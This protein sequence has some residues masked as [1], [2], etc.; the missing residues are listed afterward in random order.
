MQIGILKK[1]DEKE[2]QK[3]MIGVTPESVL[4][5][6]NIYEAQFGYDL[7]KVLSALKIDLLRLLGKVNYESDKSNINEGRDEI[8]QDIKRSK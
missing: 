7:A 1:W 8:K 2:A 3:E 5:D 4:D 6:L